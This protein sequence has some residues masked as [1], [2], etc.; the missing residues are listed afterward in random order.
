LQIQADGL[1]LYLKDNE[2]GIPSG[3]QILSTQKFFQSQMTVI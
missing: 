3:E 1:I 2:I